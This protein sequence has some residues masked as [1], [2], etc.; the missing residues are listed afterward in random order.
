MSG[1]PARAF[2]SHNHHQMGSNVFTVQNQGGGNKKAGFPY[3]VGRDHWVSIYLN[4]CNPTSRLNCASIKC[5]QF[6]VNPKVI[7]SRPI[8][9]TYVPNTYFYIPGTG[10]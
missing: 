9:S 10:R 2:N 4:S 7:V 5:L 6:T 8:G 3:Q 1:L